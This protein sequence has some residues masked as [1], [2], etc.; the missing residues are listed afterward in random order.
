MNSNLVWKITK[1]VLP[2]HSDHAGVMWHGTYFTWLEESR[3]KALSDVGLNYFDL[4]KKGFD[5]PLINTTIRYKSPLYLGEKITIE[6]VFNINKSPR[7]NI[8]SKFLNEEKEV[9]TIAEVNL[10]LIN[11]INFSIIKNRP[12]FISNAFYKL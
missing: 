1:V 3:I 4:T 8:N 10:V 6:S 11:N 2:Q 5:L 9:L 12:D 7:V